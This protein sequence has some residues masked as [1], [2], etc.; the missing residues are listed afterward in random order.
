[1]NIRLIAATNRDLAQA[2]A[3]HE[4]RSD[5]YYR[6]N[7]FPIHLP[8]LR[9]RIEDIPMLVRYFVQ[10]LSRRNNKQIDVIPVGTMDALIRWRWL[11]N[12]RELENFIERSVILTEGNVLNAPIAELIG[13]F[14]LDGDGTLEGIQ[15]EF[16][17]RK[18]RESDGV[19]SGV[20][21]AATRLGLKRTTLQSKMSKMGISR[22]DYKN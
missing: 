10:K 22:R 7:V 5:L 20:R 16:I 2:M 18:L 21:G 13:D 4:F 19:I 9:E 1:V 11:G 8:A 15:R 12:V 14:A 6:L 3:E 17:I